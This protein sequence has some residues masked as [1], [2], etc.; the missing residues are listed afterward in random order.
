MMSLFCA[1]TVVGLVGPQ[2]L[3][4][5]VDSLQQGTT[6]LRVDLIALTFV[7]VLVAEALLRRA[8]RLRAVVFG[9][10]LLAQAREDLVAH[11]VEL[12]LH[13]IESAGTG[14]L[15]S[16]AT[17]DV[18]KLDE[19][20]RQAAPEI[21]VATVTVVLTAVAMVLTAPLLALGMLVAVPIIVAA[22]HW[23]RPRAVP[24]YQRSLEYW[25]DVHSSTHET[26]EG[27]RTVEALG[28]ASRRLAHNAAAV[29]RAAAS[30]RRGVALWAGFLT[31]LDLAYLAPIAVILLL[32]GWAYVHGLVGLG[33]LT[34][35][36][37]YARAMAEPLGEVLDWMDELLIGKAALRRVLGVAQVAPDSG[38]DSLVPAGR[39]ITVRD[40]RFSYRAGR[41]VLHGVDLTIPA[42]ERLA[43]VGPSGAGKSTL[44]RLLAGIDAP[45]SGSVTVGGVEVSAL[46]LAARRREV[47]LLT[48][49]QH[50]FIGTVRDN[51]L[52]ARDATDT[53]L[54]Q[55]LRTVNAAQW[56]T[57]LPLGLGTQVGPGGAPVSPAM[58]QRIALARLVLADPH[59]LVLDEA[60]SLVDSLASRDLERALAAVFAGRTVISIT[61]RLDTTRD[62]DRIAV[63]VDGRIVELGNHAE[64][65]AAGGS[66]AA[67]FDVWRATAR[68]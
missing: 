32:G 1:A 68:A 53:E 29:D 51:L 15:L 7:G 67:L 23:Y 62:A 35:T 38:D 12:P 42:G 60:T 26:V 5:L 43:V 24:T 46:P 11:A 58:L 50:L 66:Y 40:A 64:L 27:G 9:E 56:A 36:V 63:M 17:S 13:T 41:D 2:L 3:G 33:P 20:L 8:A 16:R 55:V 28:I 6:R 30:E 44:A 21:L 10:K 25:A 49:E 37:L 14:D 65:M 45:D 47:V 52:L 39:D 31:C 19:G 22:T 59:T 57:A 54:W 18:D 4:H 61:H 34:A 48:Q